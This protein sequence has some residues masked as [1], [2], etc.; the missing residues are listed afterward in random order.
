MCYI[1]GGQKNHALG[2]HCVPSVMWAVVLAQF[3]LDA[4]ACASACGRYEGR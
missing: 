1:D 4:A 3:C 2:E